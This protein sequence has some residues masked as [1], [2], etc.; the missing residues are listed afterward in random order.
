MQFRLDPNPTLIDAL[1]SVYQGKS[2]EK[3]MTNRKVNLNLTQ[4]TRQMNFNQR[5]VGDCTLVG[6]LIHSFS[7][8]VTISLALHRQIPDSI[9]IGQVNIVPWEEQ[10]IHIYPTTTTTRTGVPAFRLIIIRTCLSLF[11]PFS[12]I[13][14]TDDEV[15]NNNNNKFSFAFRY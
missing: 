11:C 4:M 1:L 12:L 14:L 15:H 6:N 8:H 2:F 10:S 13:F 3:I 7:C 5:R 9:I